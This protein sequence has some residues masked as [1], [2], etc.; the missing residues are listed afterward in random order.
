MAAF[1]M[2]PREGGD[3]EDVVREELPEGL[4]SSSNLG[5]VDVYP[6]TSG[7]VRM[8]WLAC[9]ACGRGWGS[10]SSLG[11]VDICTQ[12]PAARLVLGFRVRGFG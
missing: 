8:L 5:A 1:R 4:A 7:K 12:P 10:S 3:D 6:A 11:A 2:R 9:R